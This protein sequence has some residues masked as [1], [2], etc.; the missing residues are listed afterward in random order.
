MT[1][2]RIQRICRALSAAASIGL[3]GPA[4]AQDSGSVGTTRSG[5]TPVEAAQ[6]LASGDLVSPNL[7][8]ALA[9]AISAGT[10]RVKC[11]AGAEGALPRAPSRQVSFALAAG[12]RQVTMSLVAR[13][14]SGASVPEFSNVELLVIERGSGVA[15]R[16]ELF[17]DG[18]MSVRRSAPGGTEPGSARVSEVTPYPPG[19]PLA[20][21]ILALARRA[22]A[23]R[24]P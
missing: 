4:I 21:E 19:D 8:P 17:P 18:S 23:L 15:E 5:A 13:G 1:I 10:V 14:D 6:P 2:M 20:R 11:D 16:A 12:A 24:C 22:W 9:A 3:A 7:S